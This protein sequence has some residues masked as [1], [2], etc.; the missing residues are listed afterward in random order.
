MFEAYCP[1]HVNYYAIRQSEWL[2]GTKESEPSMNFADFDPIFPILET[3]LETVFF[4]IF[5]R[6]LLCYIFGP[7]MVEHD[8]L[9]T[10][11]AVT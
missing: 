8:I 2:S 10:F 7:S 6:K 9:T 11:Q 1:L 3:S 4:R 5:D